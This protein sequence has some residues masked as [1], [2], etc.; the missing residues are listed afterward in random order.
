MRLALVVDA[1]VVALLLVLAV[2]EILRVQD[3]SLATLLAA[4]AVAGAVFVLDLLSGFVR[5]DDRKLL[6][7]ALA[8]RMVLTEVFHAIYGDP[9]VTTF[10]YLGVV[11]LLF[12]GWGRRWATYALVAVAVQV[13]VRQ[14]LFVLGLNQLDLISN[15]IIYTLVIGVVLSLIW[16]LLRLLDD[17]RAHHQQTQRLL[18]EVEALNEQVAASAAADERLRI[19]R[20]IH[21]SLG[22]SLTGI[23]VQLEKALAFEGRDPAVARTAMQSAQAASRR[24]LVDVRD[25][26]SSIREA[27]LFDLP[28]M[29]DGLR[30]DGEESGL[31]VTVTWHGDASQYSTAHFMALYRVAQEGL[32]NVRRHAAASSVG[33]DL[34]FGVDEATMVIR[35][36][37]CG[38]D[39]DAARGGFGL[40]GLTERVTVMGGQV[41]IVSAPDEGTSLTV[42]MPRSPL[43][44]R[45]S[46]EELT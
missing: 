16:M 17:E 21:D 46:Q 20:D 7:V 26:V 12:A 19:A 43:L 4:A 13:A 3:G 35:D 23:H 34:T 6:A 40:R 44:P 25:S 2:A 31:A 9:I 45:L 29:I 37:G 33:V 28:T 32:T 36:D 41:E 11:F 39:V 42:L 30:R 38:F 24:A 15:G 1:G 10:L 22:H 18:A 27:P 8:A 5:P 14:S